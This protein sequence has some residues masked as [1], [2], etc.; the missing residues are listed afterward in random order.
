VAHPVLITEA[1]LNPGQCRAAMAELLFE[2]YGVP[3]VQFAVDAACAY[4]YNR[5]AGRWGAEVMLRK[6]RTGHNCA[7]VQAHQPHLPWALAG[8]PVRMLLNRGPFAVVGSACGWTCSKANNGKYKH[9]ALPSASC[10]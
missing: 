1:P 7:L 6:N 3:A 9:A 2:A 8:V 5:A 4:H 10:A